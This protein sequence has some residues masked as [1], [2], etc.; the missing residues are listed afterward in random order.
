MCPPSTRIPSPGT[1]TCPAAHPRIPAAAPPGGRSGRRSVA[2][3]PN[4][5]TRRTG[6]AGRRA[7]GAHHPP[8]PRVSPT[9][10]CRTGTPPAVA[11]RQLHRPGPPRH[12][13]RRA[14]PGLP[15]ARSSRRARRTP[16]LPTGKATRAPGTGT[17][18]GARPPP[19]PAPPQVPPP[20]EG[21]RRRR[22]ATCRPGTWPRGPGGKRARPCTVRPRRLPPLGPGAPACARHPRLGSRHPR[23]GPRHLRPGGLRWHPPDGGTAGGAGGAPPPS[24]EGTPG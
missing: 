13:P 16:P 17:R 6:P 11:A 8:E 1:G 7:A 15:V 14:V 2:T 3:R 5:A 23:L 12:A 10:P 21:G 22:G 20:P 19:V 4:A 24:G 9:A 18:R